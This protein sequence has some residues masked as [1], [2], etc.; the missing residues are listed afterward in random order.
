M[1]VQVKDNQPTLSRVLRSATEEACVQTAYQTM[2]VGSH[3]RVE[4]RQ[5]RVWPFPAARFETDS[6]WRFGKTLIEVR[7]ETDV[8]DTRS[9]SWI[10]RQEV[11]LYMSTRRLT[12]KE[13]SCAVR[14]H[15]SIENRLHYVRDKTMKEDESRIRYKAGSFARMRSM[16]LNIMRFNGENNIANA[17]YR[18]ALNFKR[19]IKYQALL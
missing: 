12:A 9:K 6:T 1:L 16:A 10:P 13:A 7:R 14:Q 5:T 11:S 8:Y 2:D 19:V 18:N 3:N 4:V 17:L 15:W